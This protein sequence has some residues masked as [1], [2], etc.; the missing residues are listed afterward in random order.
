MV[1]FET[2]STANNIVYNKFVLNECK[3]PILT[4]DIRCVF[5]LLMCIAKRKHNQKH[6]FLIEV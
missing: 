5:C 1:D 4:D 6:D 3:T 2:T